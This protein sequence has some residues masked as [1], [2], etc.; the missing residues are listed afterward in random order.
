[1]TKSNEDSCFA[2]FSNEETVPQPCLKHRIPR[3]C[4]EHN[5]LLRTF[6][7]VGFAACDRYRKPIFLTAFV[8]SMLGWVFSIAAAF[9]YTTND[10]TVRNV[11]W[12]IGDVA[13]G[14]LT[15]YVGLE[16]LVIDDNNNGESGFR[17]GTIAWVGEQA[18]T[19]AVQFRANSLGGA[20]VEAENGVMPHCRTCRNTAVYTCV[21]L[22]IVS[23]ITQV[24]QITTDLQ[25]T[26]RYGDLNCQKMFGFAT[27]LYGL[28]STIET[29]RVFRLFC[30]LKSA[31]PPWELSTSLNVTIVDTGALSQIEV[32]MRCVFRFV[33]ACVREIEWSK[34][35]RGPP[36]CAARCPIPA[37]CHHSAPAHPRVA[38]NGLRAV[39]PCHL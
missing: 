8:F 23:C 31:M 30:G 2:R 28:V 19:R 17:S 7:R 6:G 3:A 16:E 37:S 39:D 21:R 38:S 36:T 32:I 1:M 22:A 34:R 11:A 12:G 33:S 25:R 13:D 35:E 18:C 14:S 27:S 5:I 20:L 4:F 24:F 29:L 9:A 26:T 10:Q 15:Y